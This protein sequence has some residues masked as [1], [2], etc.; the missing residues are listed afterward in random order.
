MTT[1]RTPRERPE[2]TWELVFKR[3]PVE[4]IKREQARRSASATSCPRSIAARLR[5]GAGGGHRPPPVVGP[6]PRQA[7]DRHVHAARQDP[8]GVAHAGGAAR[9]R[10]GREP[11]RPRRRASS[12]R[13]SASSCTGSSSATLPDVFADLE[14]AGH[15]DRRRLRRHG[16]QHHRLPRRGLAADEL[17]DAT[18]VVDAATADFYGNP[19]CANLPRKHKYSIASCPDRCNAPE[20]NCISLVGVV[21]RRPRGLRA[22]SS[23]AGSRRCRA[24]PATSACSC[25][26][27]E[28]IEI[29]GAITTRLERGPRTTACRA[30]RRG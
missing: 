20:I 11:L 29:L 8:G 18:P 23:A 6:L 4:R 2:A 22:C 15:H 28:A 10:R 25:P 21:A 24:S 30:S 27:D 19:D 14:A 1:T 5:G 17:F 3:N 9:D 26:K 16:A 13:A 7:E 12:R